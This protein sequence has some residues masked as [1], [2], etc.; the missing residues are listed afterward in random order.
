[1]QKMK[2]GSKIECD[3]TLL[4][5]RKF[6]SDWMRY[7]RSTVVL[8]VYSSETCRKKHLSILSQLEADLLTDP[9]GDSIYF[10]VAREG[11]E[12]KYVTL[13]GTSQ[14]ESL[15][16]HVQSIFHGPNCNE[17]TVHYALTDRLYRWNERKAYEH[18]NLQVLF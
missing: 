13:R 10:N 3:D 2:N 11:S 6:E 5:K 15:H 8:M 18:H 12:P 7:L 1:M 16:Y 14:L 4:T 9:E 17:E